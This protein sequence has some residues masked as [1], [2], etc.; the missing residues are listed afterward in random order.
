MQ[1]LNMSKTKE[2]NDVLSFAQAFDSKTLKTR[3]NEESVS[4]EI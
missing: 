3:S 2:F 1:L 4:N